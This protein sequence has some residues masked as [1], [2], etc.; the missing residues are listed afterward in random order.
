MKSFVMLSMCYEKYNYVIT[1]VDGIRTVTDLFANYMLK[2]F[3]RRIGAEIQLLK[4][5][6]SFVHYKCGYVSIFL[7]ER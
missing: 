6:E 5:A 3:T 2:D 1:N 4:V 7:R